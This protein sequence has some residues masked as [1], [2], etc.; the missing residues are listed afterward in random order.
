MTSAANVYA[1]NCH[2]VP[3]T[4]GGRRGRCHFIKCSVS[5]R[6]CN[7]ALV[8][9]NPGIRDEDF[10]ILESCRNNGNSPRLDLPL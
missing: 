8:F 10:V 1:G 6:D 9:A 2:T 3:G 5:N 4:V 7:P